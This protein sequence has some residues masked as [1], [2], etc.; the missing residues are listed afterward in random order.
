VA[1]D[2]LNTSRA[3]MELLSTEPGPQ[4]VRRLLADLMDFEDVNRYLIEKITAIG[5]RYDFGAGDELL[6]RRLRDVALKQ[7]RLYGLMHR[8]RGLLLDQ[9]GRLSVAGWADRVDH[10]VDASEELDAPAV[11]LRPDGHVAWVGADQQDLLAHL[12]RWFGAAAS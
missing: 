10:V 8:G 11:L 5:V 9:T 1:E 6:G 7:G 2:V 12:P 4:A 3:Q